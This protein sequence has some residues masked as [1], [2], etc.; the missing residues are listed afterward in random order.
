MGQS[1]ILASGTSAATSSDVT[2]AAGSVVSVGIF[3]SSGEPSQMG[4]LASVVM[5][6]PG[7]DITIKTLSAEEPATVLS[8]PGTFRVVRP[9][10]SSAIG[11]FSET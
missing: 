11:A 5:D 6:T 2:V 4:P 1:T 9:A 8:G 7:G 10:L 3:T